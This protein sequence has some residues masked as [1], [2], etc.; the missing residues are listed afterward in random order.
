MLNHWGNQKGTYFY[1]WLVFTLRSTVGN[2]L[3]NYIL[4]A[5]HAYTTFQI[6]K[7]L[8]LCRNCSAFMH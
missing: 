6:N 8:E 3:I 1:K 2:Q 5:V 4:H 7:C